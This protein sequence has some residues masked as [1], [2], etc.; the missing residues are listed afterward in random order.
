M[1][2][3]RHLINYAV[4]FITVSIVYNNARSDI[5]CDKGACHTANATAALQESHA[6][7]A[8]QTV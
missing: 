8:D 1:L 6:I 5:V 4:Y 7:R 2:I 3:T